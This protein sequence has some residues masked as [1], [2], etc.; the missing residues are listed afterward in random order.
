[1]SLKV[2]W[3]L[4]LKG[5]RAVLTSVLNAPALWGF[6]GAFIYAGTVFTS[7]FWADEPI[8]AP[9]R[10]RLLAEFAISIIVGPVLAEGFGPTLFGA[11]WLKALDHRAI[12]LS[13]GLASNYIWPIA[14]KALGSRVKLFARGRI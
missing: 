5:N 13:I 4:G 14:V 10:Y 12:S 6:L 2:R 3:G 1:M 9:K 7:A 11:Q 8:T